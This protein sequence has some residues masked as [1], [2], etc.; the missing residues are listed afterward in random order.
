MNRDGII[1]AGVIGTGFIAIPQM[2]SIRRIPGIE[3]A[4]VCDPAPE[5]LKEIKKAYG[6]ERGYTDWRDMVADKD[7]QVIHNCTPNHLHDKINRAAILAG[8]HIYAEKPLSLGAARAKSLWQLAMERG[9]AHG[10]NHQYRLSGAVQEMRARIMEGEGGRPLYVSGCYL[11]DSA[12]RHTDYTS[13][14]MPETSPARALA[15]IGVHWADTVTCVMGQPIQAVYAQMYTHYPLRL[16]TA[17]GREVEINSDDT[18]FVMV[19]FED[20]TPGTAVFS[21]CAVGHKND[22]VVTVSGEQRE[23]TWRQ[24]NGDRLYIG[25]RERGN[26]ELLTG[27]N[28]VHEAVL[29]YVTMPAGHA[30]GWQ[31]VLMHAIESFYQSIRTE[32]YLTGQ[33]PYATFYD[34]WRGNAFIEACVKSAR[35]GR[36]TELAR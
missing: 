9:V 20:G 27:S 13:R 1:R 17:T 16:D 19:R 7:I 21:K 4:A 6:I 12:A 26:E 23:Y 32:Q 2:D 28:L 29:P 24:Q 35:T 25:N 22:L 34:G 3:L 31:D 8:K 14:Q 11:Q 5:R 33:V 15:D 10:V 36:W 30:M 18:T